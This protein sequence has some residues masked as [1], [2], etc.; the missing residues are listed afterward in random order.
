M[1]NR[2]LL[3]RFFSTSNIHLTKISQR[4]DYENYFFQFSRAA[5]WNPSFSDA[6]LYFH[7]D[8]SHFYLG[9]VNYVPAFSVGFTIFK[10]PK[11]MFAGM[12]YCLPEYRHVGNCFLYATTK[13]HELKKGCDILALPGTPLMGRKYESKMGTK[14]KGKIYRRRLFVEPEKMCSK[15][16]DSNL[17]KDVKQIDI[18]KLIKYD[19]EVCGYDR[20]QILKKLHQIDPFNATTLVF[21]SEG[22][23]KGYGILRRCVEGYKIGPLLA[24]NVKT[25]SEI[26]HALKTKVVGNGD[27]LVT[28][29]TSELAE[30]WNQH[31]FWDKMGFDFNN[32]KFFYLQCTERFPAN[33]RKTFAIFSLEVGF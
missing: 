24:E 17:I 28:I 3:K 7:P 31:E 10:E 11:I 32:E 26:L 6:D 29:D 8:I 16:Y 15:S 14:I 4:T 12:Y 9:Y 18:N 25:A 20:S 30:E 21:E 23:V 27:V 5:R 1:L 13:F 22:E 19:R 33:W 2:L